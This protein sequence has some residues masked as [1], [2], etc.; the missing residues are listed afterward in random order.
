MTKGPTSEQISAD[1]KF[2]AEARKRSPLYPDI[3]E[4]LE[5]Q[6]RQRE[7]I[8]ARTMLALVSCGFAGMISGWVCLGGMVAGVNLIGFCIV[9]LVAGNR[10]YQRNEGRS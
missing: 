8:A 3:N 9:C 7:T 4:A 5:R 6:Q 2:F 1:Q 10:S